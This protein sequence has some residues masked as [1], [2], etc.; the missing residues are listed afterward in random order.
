MYIFA[1]A[2]EDANWHH[3]KSYTKKRANIEKVLLNCGNQLQLMKIKNGQ[4]NIM[5]LIQR[6]KSFGGKVVVTLNNGKKIIEQL[7]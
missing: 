2:L 1:V 4:K 5:I 6:N 7:R 3:V